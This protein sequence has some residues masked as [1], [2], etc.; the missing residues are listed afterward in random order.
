MAVTESEWLEAALYNKVGMGN[1]ACLVFD[2]ERL[3]L[4]PYERVSVLFFRVRKSGP[5]L[6]LNEEFAIG[7]FDLEQHTGAMAKDTGDLACFI[8]MGYETVEILIVDEGIHGSLPANNHDRVV[9]IRIDL[10]E[11]RGTLD[12]CCVL[13]GLQKTQAEDVVLGILALIFRMTKSINFQFSSSG[14]ANMYLVAVLS[15]LV[16]RMNQFRGPEANRPARLL[17]D[18]GVRSNHQ[19]LFGVLRVQNINRR[20]HYVSFFKCSDQMSREK[21][22]FFA[23]I[24]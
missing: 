17:R 22:A 14:A 3:N 21:L 20:A 6:A 4:L 10:L 16:V 5:G 13:G 8:E 19:H 1:L 11:R 18:R 12:Q 24:G 9:F 23:D 15:E 2:T 7:E